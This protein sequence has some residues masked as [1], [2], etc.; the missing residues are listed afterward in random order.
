MKPQAKSSELHDALAAANNAAR[1]ARLVGATGCDRT[2][3]AGPDGKSP[4][5]FQFLSAMRA[6]GYHVGE[7]YIPKTQIR[8]GHTAWK[9][10]LEIQGVAATLVFF[11][12]GT[13]P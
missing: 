9:V 11:T 3:I 13:S 7:P 10:A 5:P 12:P 8:P 2:E 1:V 4:D 6:R